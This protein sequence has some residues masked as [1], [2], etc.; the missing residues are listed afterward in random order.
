MIPTM[1]TAAEVLRGRCRIRQRPLVAVVPGSGLVTRSAVAGGAD[2]LL[3]LNAGHFRSLGSGSLASFLA[4]SNANDATLELLQ[5]HILPQADDTPVIAGVLAC[6]PQVDLDAHL[7]GLME[8]GVAG[9]T[10]WPAVGFVDGRFGAALA[11]E[12]FT[13]ASEVAFL[14]RAR[15]LGLVACGFALSPEAAT[16]FAEIGCE[17]LIC[18]LGLTS[19]HENVRDRR[20]HLERAAV[21]LSTLLDAAESASAVGH[22]P[23]CLAFG[24]P[25]TEPDDLDVLYRDHRVRG[26]AGGSTFERLPIRNAVES[27]VRRFTAV[28]PA[29]AATGSVIGDSAVMQDLRRLIARVAPHDVPVII[30][31]ESGSGKE[32]VAQEIHRLSPRAGG[33]LVTLNCG[34]IPAGLLESELFGHEKG[35][36]TGADRKRL[37]KF[38]LAAGGTLFLDEIADLSAAGQVALLRAIQA[39]EIVRVGGDAAIAVDARIV[40]ASNRPLPALVASGV[41]RADLYYRLDALTLRVPPL[42]ERREDLPALTAHILS[43]LTSRIN[44]RLLGVSP[45]FAERLAQ[46]R[47]P[48]N[49]RE[50]EQALCRAAL[51]EDGSILEGR[52]FEVVGEPAS[53]TPSRAQRARQA[54]IAADGV[55]SRAAATLGISRKTLYQWLADSLP[56]HHEP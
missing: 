24:G 45:G 44:R 4:Y 7:R 28:R 36:F 41:F 55:K 8:L 1:V 19:D 6:D 49:V 2:C 33:P 53:D 37:G 20:D 54:L 16:A 21:Q 38:E 13:L 40:C 34:A 43:R 12:G 42:R 31:G 52:R 46:H 5:H 11:D 15:E 29:T 22:T 23:V 26:F 9:V 48:G 18:N 17:L 14:K 30:D 10:N 25:V 56:R 50:L 39:R 35:A 47:W 27:T 32:L 3:A 51:L